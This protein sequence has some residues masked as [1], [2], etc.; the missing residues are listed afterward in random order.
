MQK[1]GPM[2]VVAGRS[3]PMVR[4]GAGFHDDLRLRLL[5]QEALELTS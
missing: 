1:P 5:R 2:A 3:C 4:G